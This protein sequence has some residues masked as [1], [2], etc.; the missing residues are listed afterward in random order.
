MDAPYAGAGRDRMTEEREALHR[1]A[2]QRSREERWN[3]PGRSRV[4]H[5]KYGSVVVPH[6]S[7]LTALLNA[8]EYW[9]CDWLEIRDAE[10]L[11][12][13]PGDGPVVKPREFIGKGG[14]LA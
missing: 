12:T 13:K 8:A 6:S 4:V 3:D 10:V 5:P 14:E 7:N 11:A 9:G 2:Y 1:R